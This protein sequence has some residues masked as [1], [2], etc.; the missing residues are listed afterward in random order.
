MNKKLLDISEFQQ[1]I[2]DI[3]NSFYPKIDSKVYS[4]ALELVFTCFLKKKDLLNLIIADV[5]DASGNILSLIKIKKRNL[6]LSQ[7]VISLISGHIAYLKSNNYPT[8]SQSPLMPDKNHKKYNE[9][10]IDRHLKK[11]PQS[12]SKKIALDKIRQAGILYQYQYL[13]NINKMDEE[14]A[15]KNLSRLTRLQERHVKGIITGNIQ[16]TGKTNVAQMTIDPI[17]LLKSNDP[18]ETVG[19]LRAL[20]KIIVFDISDTKSILDY[21]ELFE[22]A[23]NRN[24]NLDKATQDIYIRTFCVLF[25]RR[26]VLLGVASNDKIESISIPKKEREEFKMEQKSI[27]EKFLLELETYKDA[28]ADSEDT[29]KKIKQIFESSPEEHEDDAKL[30]PK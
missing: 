20:D 19:L 23:V 7:D 8:S 30:L 6:P 3:K 27:L 2:G 28:E 14:Q 17:E 9:K 25:G 21:K 12:H 4:F 24:T 15:I 10:K 26:G 29:V 22:N 1:L 11:F 5:V 18:I 13:K 16:K